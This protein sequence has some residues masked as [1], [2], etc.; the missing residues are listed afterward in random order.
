MLASVLAYP[1]RR[2]T[3]TPSPDANLHPYPATRNLNLMGIY[4]S[5]S[6]VVQE[7]LVGW[8]RI[9][10]SCHIE[11]RDHFNQTVLVGCQ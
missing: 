1:G 7:V 9:L 6:A 11:V 5:T 2:A 10:D 8:L 4:Y 3:N